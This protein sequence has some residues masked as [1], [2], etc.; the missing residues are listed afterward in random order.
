MFKSSLHACIIFLF[1]LTLTS[2]SAAKVCFTRLLS[3]VRQFNL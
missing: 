2:N 3:T 1:T